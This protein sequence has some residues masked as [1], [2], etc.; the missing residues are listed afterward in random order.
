MYAVLTVSAATMLYF[1]GMAPFDAINHALTTVSTGGFS[2][3]MAGIEAFASPAV[4]VIIA[5]F[6]FF[7]GMNFLLQYRLFRFGDWRAVRDDGEFW[8]YSAL[9]LG[10]GCIIAL[11]LWS[12]QAV[13]AASALRSGF[14]PFLS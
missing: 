2:T 12:G 8:L 11:A 4:E 9:A 1:A 6:M 10:A 5:V 3:R 14:R 13:P 7:G